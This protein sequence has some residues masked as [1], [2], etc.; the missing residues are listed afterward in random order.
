MKVVENGI[1][2]L[3][4][5]LWDGST[6]ITADGA[7]NALRVLEY[8]HHE[9]HAGN[10]FNYCRSKVLGNT[11]SVAIIITTPNTTKWAHL[12]NVVQGTQETNLKLFED[13][14]PSGGTSGAIVNRNRNS[15]TVPTTTITSGA[16]VA[17]GNEGNLLCEKQFGSSNRIGGLSRGISEFVLK[18]NTIYYLKVTNA[19]ASNNDVS[20]SINWYE[21]VSL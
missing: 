4:V 9:L 2:V 16:V 19:T 18:Q 1:E 6:E 7:T 13:A 15:A 5:Q 14:I 17:G 21:H 8:P 11:S 10:S 3:H 12:V 20:Y